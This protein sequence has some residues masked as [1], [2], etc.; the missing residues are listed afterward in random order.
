MYTAAFLKGG[1]QAMAIENR[2][3]PLGTRLVANYKKTRYVCTVA[4]GE[5]G[6]VAYVLEGGQRFKSPSAAA[7]FVMSG[8]AA[9]G[10]RFW[11]VEGDEP[12]AKA[13]PEAKPERKSRGSRKKPSKTIFKTSSQDG[14]AEGKSSWFC[15]A[16]MDAFV[17]DGADEP[18]ACPKGHRND[19]PELNAPA[20]VS[21]ADEAQVTA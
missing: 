2:N 1:P 19:D 18:E 16:C 20:G 13:A 10:W 11:T 21:A 9:N 8:Q 15:S 12:E 5:E 3:L 14:V 6:S 7:S 4:V 17:I